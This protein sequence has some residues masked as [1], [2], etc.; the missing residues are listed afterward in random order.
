MKILKE[1]RGQVA[2]L[3]ILG[4]TVLMGFMALA[5]DVGTMYNVKRRVQTAA[6]AAAIAAAVNYNFG[7]T[8]STAATAAGTAARNNGIAPANTVTANT[9]CT[10]TQLTSN[11]TEAF[12]G[13]NITNAYHDTSGYVE[14]IVAQP[15]P[16]FFLGA[17]TA[18]FHTSTLSVPISAKAVAG[19]VPSTSCTN[20]TDKT[21]PDTF[22]TKGNAYINSATCGIQIDSTSTSAACMKG[23]TSITAPYINIA[24][25]QDTGSGCGKNPGS[26][27]NTYAGQ[28]GDPFNNLQ[29]PTAA[30]CTAANT[31]TGT[32]Y[33]SD[34]GKFTSVT[35]GSTTANVECFSGTNVS[36]SGT[37]GSSPSTNGDIFVFQNG[38]TIGG[39]TTVNG[40]MDIASGNFLQGNVALTVNAP[41]SDN[42]SAAKSLTYNSIA[43]LQPSSNTTACSGEDSSFKKA[44]I[45]SSEPCLQLQFGSGYGNLNGYV[46]APTSALYIQDSGG[47]VQVAGIVAY[48]MY[49]STGTL[50]ITNYNQ[51]N[52]SSTPLTTI[53]LVE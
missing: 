1:E 24:G 12:F 33:S 34:P 44:L 15:N 19:I 42:N 11:C 48:S 31:N 18:L 20:V 45:T 7:G 32:S 8:T 46:Y 23:S 2:M 17:F 35:T 30:N 16:S 40:T 52:A 36:I 14:A 43:I 27:V 13:T 9:A 41:G 28:E 5:I 37:F 3:T 53:Q 38:V 29:G 51:S 39:T 10:S 25:A 6:D 21:D 49:M 50:T 26:P 22:S 4:M 47:A